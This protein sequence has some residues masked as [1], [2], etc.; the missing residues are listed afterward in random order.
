[1]IVTVPLRDVKPPLGVMIRCPESALLDRPPVP[2]T[3][4]SPT[5][6]LGRVGAPPIVDAEDS[7]KP[8]ASADDR[9][10]G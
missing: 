6:P 9:C 10:S 7:P 4:A 5:P 8:K 2:V 1:V 3:D